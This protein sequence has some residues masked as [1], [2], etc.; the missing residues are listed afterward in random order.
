MYH[1]EYGSPV[2]RDRL[3]F[4]GV[5]GLQDGDGMANF[6][7]K[8]CMTGMRQKPMDITRFIVLNDADRATIRAKYKLP[9]GEGAAARCSK[10]EPVFRDEHCE[11]FKHAG[12]EWP[13]ALTATAQQDLHYNLTGLG[14]RAL[15]VVYFLDKHFPPK[16][17]GTDKPE[18]EFL[19]VNNS[20]GRLL[21][22]QSSSSFK[23]FMELQ[24]PWAPSP[25]TITGQSKIVMRSAQVGVPTSVRCLEGW[26]VMSL[27]GW[28]PSMWKEGG[29]FV[30]PEVMCN[31]AGNA[32]SGFAVGPVLVAALSLLGRHST[33]APA[34]SPGHAA[35]CAGDACNSGSSSESD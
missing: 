24:S 20:L 32:F 28:S 7:F 26:E 17:V 23:E 30:Q 33:A 2:A 8:N 35:G 1:Q 11:L 31:M 34:P 27:I 21:K 5:H 12:L 3:Y 19:D 16:I 15:E 25:R 22:W 18:L 10:G 4:F 9:R 29:P 6:L 13:P 14:E